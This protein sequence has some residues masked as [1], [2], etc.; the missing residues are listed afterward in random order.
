MIKEY[1]QSN[2]QRFLDELFELLRI[3]SVSADSRHK[4]DVRKAAEYV[5]KKLKDAGADTAEL[6]ETAGTPL[7]MEKK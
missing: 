1:I 3:P 2:Q 4:G 5:V 6:C 7:S